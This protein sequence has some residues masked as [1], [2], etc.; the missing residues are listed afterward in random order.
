[1]VMR[2]KKTIIAAVT[3]LKIIKKNG[4]IYTINGTVNRISAVTNIY[5]N[6]GQTIVTIY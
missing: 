6:K 3:F 4:H 2:I 5:F 1:M